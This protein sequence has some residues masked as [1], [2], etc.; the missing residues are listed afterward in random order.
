[1][2]KSTPEMIGPHDLGGLDAGPVDRAE[3]DV[4]YWER[5]VDA[6]MFMLRKH[7]IMKDVS[8]LRDG[9]E[10]LGPD[11]YHELSYYERWAA[12]AAATAVAHGV[13]SE[14]ELEARIAELKAK[15]VAK[16]AVST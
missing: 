3:H 15:Q 12:S 1:M 6:V 4:A 2:S 11:V 5:Q 16:P 14:Q 13:V 9:I 8:Q 7:G 10:R